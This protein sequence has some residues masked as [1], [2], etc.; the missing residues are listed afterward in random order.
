MEGSF[1]NLQGSSDNIIPQEDP[2]SKKF[3]TQYDYSLHSVP[4]RMNEVAGKSIGSAKKLANGHTGKHRKR[5]HKR[6]KHT[7]LE[8]EVNP[9]DIVAD[10][11][12][13][14]KIRF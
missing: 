6:H 13:K 11:L 8:D 1:N 2:R 7:K 4:I 10:I 5:H 12:S 14:N 3:S 9:T